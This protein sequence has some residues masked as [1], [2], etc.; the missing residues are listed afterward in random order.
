M[1]LHLSPLII[2]IFSLEK[3]KDSDCGRGLWT[4]N[5]FFISDSKYIESMTKHICE[6][7]CLLHNQHITDEHLRWEYLKYGLQKFTEKNEEAI[8]ENE[9][10]K[11]SLEIECKHLQT[12]LNNCHTS[13]KYLDCKSKLDEI[14]FEKADGVRIRSKYDLYKSS[15]NSNTFF[16]NLEKIRVSQCLFRTLVKN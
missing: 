4:F 2:N 5:K 8:V 13:E 7:F 9:R 12:D 6:A 10:K 11:Y 16:F 1:F 3:I 14:Y 15:E